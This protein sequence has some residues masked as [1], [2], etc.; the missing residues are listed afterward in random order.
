MKKNAKCQ[1][2]RFKLVVTKFAGKVEAVVF[3][4]FG[5]VNSFLCSDQWDYLA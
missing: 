1:L 4:I 3:C 5:R 2:G